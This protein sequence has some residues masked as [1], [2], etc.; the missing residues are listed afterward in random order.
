MRHEQ[1]MTPFVS[2]PGDAQAR[3]SMETTIK[4]SDPGLKSIPN[5]VPGSIESL[6]SD[7]ESSSERRAVTT[8][9]SS[10]LAIPPCLSRSMPQIYKTVLWP[11]DLSF[12]LVREKDM[13]AD[14]V[15][16]NR[17]VI[18]QAVVNGPKAKASVCFVVKRPGCVLC[19]EQGAALSAL[20]SEFADH[21]VGAWAVVKEINVDNDGLLSL[22]Q[23]YF[24]FPFFRDEKFA[25]YSA[26]GDRRVNIFQNPLKILSIKKRLKKKGI[27]G[28]IIGKGEGMILGGVIIFDREGRIRYAHQ[29]KFTRELPVDEIRS[30][31]REVVMDD[32]KR[33]SIKDSSTPE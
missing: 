21:L 10:A 30:A 28:N 26:L 6:Q 4:E 29:E 18:R 3:L 17:Q 12:G 20:I 31:I 25:L 8:A 23:N 33:S 5:A 16:A 11:L 14:L 24:R 19:F 7:S 1:C 22:Y 15:R 13:A 27:E 2:R 9:E 32:T